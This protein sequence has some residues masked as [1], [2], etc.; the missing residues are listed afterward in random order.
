MKIVISLKWMYE[1]PLNCFSVTQYLKTLKLRVDRQGN[2]L[3][4]ETAT[5]VLE[6]PYQHN[7]TIGI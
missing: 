3:K 7:L 6:I 1:K 2:S 5:E 4:I